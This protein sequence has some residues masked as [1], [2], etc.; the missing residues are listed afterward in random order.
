MRNTPE[1]L[2]L[3]LLLTSCASAATEC[4]RV[5]NVDEV[6]KQLERAYA[7]NEAAFSAHDVDAV[8]KLRHPDFHTI[9]HAGK[10]STRQEMEERTR[11]FLRPIERFNAQ[12]ETIQALEVHGDTAI[13]RVHQELS[14]TQRLG[15]GALHQVDTT[16]TQREW[17]RCTD[18]GW[19]LWRVD[20]VG[21]G[22]KLVDGKPPT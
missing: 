7:A 2:C 19:Q 15:D 20:E 1:A 11:A 16:V 8:M 10:L 4:A 14:R 9:D 5:S 6:R 3:F 17:W 13:V 21:E 18:K 22:T 12:R